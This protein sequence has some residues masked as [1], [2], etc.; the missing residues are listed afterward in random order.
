MKINVVVQNEEDWAFV[1]ID[2]DDK[3]QMAVF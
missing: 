2:K 1:W 3:K